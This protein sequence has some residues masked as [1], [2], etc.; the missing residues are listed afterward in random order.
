MRELSP[1][2]V[3]HIASERFFYEAIASNAN[4]A[5]VFVALERAASSANQA[6]IFSPIF[7]RFDAYTF[8]ETAALAIRED[9]TFDAARTE[10]LIDAW[11]TFCKNS[12]E[13]ATILR[14]QHCDLATAAALAG[15]S[16]VIRMFCR[17]CGMTRDNAI[18]NLMVHQNSVARLCGPEFDLSN[19]DEAREII[20]DAY[21]VCDK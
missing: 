3:G 19:F 10:S 6:H 16:D 18:D 17:K 9:D 14:D 2:Q 11:L 1:D 13:A 20:Q 21:S 8:F 4:S 12:P 15:K 5:G 7:F